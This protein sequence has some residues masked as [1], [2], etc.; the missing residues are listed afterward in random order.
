MKIIFLFTNKNQVAHP[1]WLED[2]LKHLRSHALQFPG[3][4]FHIRIDL[5]IQSCKTIRC[6]DQ[7]SFLKTC[8]AKVY[9][10]WSINEF[11][12]INVMMKFLKHK[13][14]S[15]SLFVNL[16]ISSLRVVQCLG[17]IG[18]RAFILLF[19]SMEQHCTN[20]NIW[21]MTS[22]AYTQIYIKMC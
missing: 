21:C 2:D 12:S 3:F 22:N 1:L 19:I 11:S 6:H 14:Y 20:P 10:L 16:A 4:W 18:Y 7:N 9:D 8:S 13:D 15:E 5:T 17:Y